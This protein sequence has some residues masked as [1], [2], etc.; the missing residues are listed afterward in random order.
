MWKM[1]TEAHPMAAHRLDSAAMLHTASLPD[2]KEG[3]ESFLEKRPPQFSA[4][5]SQDMPACYP[6]WDEAM[7]SRPGRD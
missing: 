2:A 1:L 7:F 5:P 4:R 3:I 6:W